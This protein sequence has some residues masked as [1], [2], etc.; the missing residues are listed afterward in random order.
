MPNQ[1]VKT[2][3]NNDIFNK[4]D[5]EEKAYWLGFLY[6]DG[7]IRSKEGDNQIEL[8]LQE[9]DYQQIANFRNFIGN[10]NKIAYREK[11]KAYRYCFRSAQI[12]KD[13]INL[14][15]VPN[16]SLILTFPTEEQVPNKFLNDFIRG[17]FDGD[18]WLGKDK[19]KY[20]IEILG[21]EYFLSGL[22]KRYPLFYGRK[23]Y[24]N[25]QK[26]N[27]VIKRLCCSKK[28]ETR[29]FLQDIYGHANVY[30]DRKY[31]RYLATL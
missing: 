14:G 11:Q 17:Y 25:N 29:Q 4:I 30:L 6:A 23:L 20:S 1:Y 28:S 16:K 18:G 2:T 5:S 8:S 26:G 7:T 3:T 9:R 12:K 13:L 27:P 22:Q 19:Y 21:T 31:K 15:C 10:D 24:I